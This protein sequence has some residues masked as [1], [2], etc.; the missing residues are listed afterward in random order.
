MTERTGPGGAQPETAREKSD[1]LKAARLEAEREK[2]A[3]IERAQRKS[4]A[5]HKILG[6]GKG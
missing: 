3:R 2:T 1:R 6:D 5:R 4:V